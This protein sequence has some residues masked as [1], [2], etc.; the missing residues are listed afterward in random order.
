ME[1]KKLAK[2][3]EMIKTRLMLQKSSESIR[4]QDD[5]SSHVVNPLTFAEAEGTEASAAPWL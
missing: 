1:V 4:A 3:R 5:I 2:K